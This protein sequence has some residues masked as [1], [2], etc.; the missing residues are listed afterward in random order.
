[1]NI[2]YYVPYH[3]KPSW[4]IGIVMHHVSLLNKNGFNA[5]A[6]IKDKKTSYTWLNLKVRTITRKQ[7]Y[8][9][10]ID[11]KD[12]LV[13]PEVSVNL[14]NLKKL[15]CRKILFIQNVGYIYNSLPKFESHESLGFHYVFSIMPHMGSI[16]DQ[17]IGLPK[18]MIPP[19]I[20]NIFH[21]DKKGFTL[22]KD[23]ITIFPKFDQPD[24][25]IVYN[26]LEK[27]INIG[28]EKL[29][30][31]KNWKI[32][33]LKNLTHKEV[34]LTLKKSKIFIALNTFESLNA[35]IVE[36]MAAG[37]IVFTYEG[38][39]SKDFIRNGVNCYSFPNNEPYKLVSALL[40]FINDG[41]ND[42]GQYQSLIEEGQSTARMYNAEN[43]EKQLTAF[44]STLN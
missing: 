16:I 11:Q 14:E 9:I 2:Y 29:S 4:G 21:L 18:I 24:Y 20:S 30:T 37:C 1:M 13:V 26:I 44:F 27:K 42:I 35:S 12:V 10:A 32:E 15:E 43:T 33:E 5:Y 40:N 22:K 7:F 41:I 34:A 25:H 28:K 3:E 31:G 38:Y 19:F 36:A 39:G 17:Y 6:V 23:I 8:S